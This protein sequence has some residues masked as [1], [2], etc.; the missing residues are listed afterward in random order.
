LTLSA[1]FASPCN[2]ICRATAHLV[3]AVPCFATTVD[4][5]ALMPLPPAHLHLL[6]YHANPPCS[7]SW[8]LHN[9]RGTCIMHVTM[10]AARVRLCGVPDLTL[11]SY[12]FG[13][14]TIV[15]PFH[16]DNHRPALLR[17]VMALLPADSLLSAFC[18]GPG[19]LPPL[20]PPLPLLIRRL[21]S[22]N[23]HAVFCFQCLSRS[24]LTANRIAP[25][26]SCA[27]LPRGL[28]ICILPSI[29]LLACPPP[30]PLVPYLPSG[31]VPPPPTR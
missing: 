31:F 5:P 18:R 6:I 19:S 10:L 2:F 20:S 25:L 26:P 3:Y 12:S 24:R 14:P 21:Q 8:T 30:L 1:G 17:Q 22:P 13:P 27:P 7:F 29:F 15:I 28:L 9:A 4:V 16:H 23:D 11:C